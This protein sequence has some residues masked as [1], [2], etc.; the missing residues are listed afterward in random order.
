MNP[1]TVAFGSAYQERLR[2]RP[3]EA[4]ATTH[5]E[6]GANSCRELTLLER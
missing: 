1:H 6:E 4:L 5:P 2:G 3:D